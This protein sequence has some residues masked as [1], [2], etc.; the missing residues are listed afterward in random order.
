MTDENIVLWLPIKI[1]LFVLFKFPYIILKRI[2]VLTPK[3]NHVMPLYS[4]W[5]G[6][7]KLNVCGGGL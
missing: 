3:K 6:L 4:Q 1:L 7:L 5:I 2:F